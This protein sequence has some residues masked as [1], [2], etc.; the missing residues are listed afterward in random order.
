[1]AHWFSTV[2]SYFPEKSRNFEFPKLDFTTIFAHFRI[3][4]TF[5]RGP[6]MELGAL[7]P[8]L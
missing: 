2:W 6:T 7:A 3:E 4:D 1:M 8:M 5:R